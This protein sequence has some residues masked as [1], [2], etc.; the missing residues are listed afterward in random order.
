M[1][2][3]STKLSQFLSTNAI[4]EGKKVNVCVLINGK[5]ITV[6]KGIIKE[7]KTSKDKSVVLD[8]IVSLPSMDKWVDSDHYVE[9]TEISKTSD[10]AKWFL[11]GKLKAR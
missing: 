4:T 2:N 3:F 9:W 11:K 5:F 6:G 10:G 7:A 1:D 8:S